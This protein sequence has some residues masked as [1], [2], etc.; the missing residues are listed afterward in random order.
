MLSAAFFAVVFRVNL[1]VALLT[2][3][4]T[5]P[6]TILPLYVLAYELGAWVLGHNHM[7]AA[8]IAL[9]EL[10]WHDWF[11]PLIHWMSSLGKAFIIGLPLLAVL[12]AVLGYFAVR[13]AWRY[14]VLWELRQR[15]LRRNGGRRNE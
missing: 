15:R 7:V 11:F 8:P 13:F 2:T 1:P 6:F 10:Y 9:P 4:Y 14:R 3:L 12:L 5:N